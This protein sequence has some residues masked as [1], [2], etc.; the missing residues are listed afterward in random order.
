MVRTIDG[1]SQACCGVSV[2]SVLT[3][4]GNYAKVDALVVRNKPLGY[5][6]LIGIDDIC[7]LGGV[8]ILPTGEVRF[9]RKRESCASITIEEQDFCAAFDQ[10]KKAWT[11]RW[12]WTKNE[13][14]VQLHNT[15]SEYTVSDERRAA[16]KIELQTWIT[17]GWLIPYPQ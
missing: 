11:A 10:E 15:I 3:E 7:A 8:E 6:L 2:I 12:K 1:T 4:S 9:W 16:Y 17:N 14:P 13:A 5:D